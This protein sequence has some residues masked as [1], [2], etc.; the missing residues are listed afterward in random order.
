MPDI[1]QFEFGKP[2]DVAL[3]TV[4]SKIVP[5]QYS[6]EGRA[7]FQL[8]DGRL[9]F[10]DLLTAAKIKSLGVQPG[11]CFYVQKVK[12]GRQTEYSV[13][14][15]APE[16]QAESAP[17]RKKSIAPHVLQDRLPE[18]VAARNAARNGNLE[19]TLTA[20]IAQAVERKQEGTSPVR[21]PWADVLADQV[22][23][24]VDVYAET[25]AYASNKHGN[26]VKPETIQS[27]LVTCFINLAKRQEG[28]RAAA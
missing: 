12:K 23:T 18:I 7:M 9:M 26:N 27:L 20:S 14:R 25:V 16:P 21:A 3:Q 2:V 6:P 22:R 10:H 11:E 5:S 19:A 28:G 4:E 24:V 13:F 17:A 15:D 1:V 8:A